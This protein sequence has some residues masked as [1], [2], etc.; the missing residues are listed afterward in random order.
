[1][2]AEVCTYVHAVMLS[3]PKWRH[4]VCDDPAGWREISGLCSMRLLQEAFA[5]E[6]WIRY[7]EVRWGNEMRRLGSARCLCCWRCEG[8]DVKM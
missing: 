6:M 4:R 1:M 2:Y 5:V 3:G 8:E 7:E